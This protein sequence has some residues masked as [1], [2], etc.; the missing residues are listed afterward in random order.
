MKPKTVAVI[1]AGS[2]G[3]TFAIHLVQRSNPPKV[4][5]YEHFAAAAQDIQARRENRIFLPGVKIPTGVQITNNLTDAIATSDIIFNSVPTQFIRDVYGPI[6]GSRDVWKGKVLVNLSKGIE[7]RSGKTI[8]GVFSELFPGLR[9]S[10]YAVLS[11]PSHAEEV[12]LGVPTAAVVSGPAGLV[13]RVRETVSGKYFRLYTNL[14]VIGVEIAGSLKNCIA[15][16]A[17]ICA[18]VGFGD[19]TLAAIMTR[20]LAEISRLGC[21]LGA[22]PETFSGLAGLGDLV[23]TCM[24][25]HSR[26]RRYGEFLAKGLTPA[27]I[28]SRY[29][30]VAEGAPTS[31]AAVRLARHADVDIP[32]ISEVYRII[33]RGKKVRDA[34]ESLL[35]RPF[36]PEDARFV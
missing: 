11:G 35:S 16:S 4:V 5:L 3:T 7:I 15:I 26:N 2:W 24:S 23:V 17:G 22:K 10:Q 33:Y 21:A 31:K 30:F 32:I 19:N 8:S 18:G 36:K 13:Q 12:L 14:D 1:G 25:R 27:D 29:R 9:K 20:G 34:V 6:S 28:V